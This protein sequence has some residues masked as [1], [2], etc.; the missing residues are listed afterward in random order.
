MTRVLLLLAAAIA[1][2]LFFWLRFIGQGGL[3]AHEAPGVVTEAT[4]PAAVVAASDAA[5]AEAADELL[6]SRPKQIL[7]GDLHVHTTFS[8]DAFML[9]LPMMGGLSRAVLIFSERRLD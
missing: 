6:V 7:F 1:A 9:S 4:R 8:F 5:V 2:T 3:G